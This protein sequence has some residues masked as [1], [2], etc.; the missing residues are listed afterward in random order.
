M[1]L[2][3]LLTLVLVDCS[4]Q[5]TTLSWTNP[6]EFKDYYIGVNKSDVFIIKGK[7]DNL[8]ADNFQYSFLQAESDVAFRTLYRFNSNKVLHS[9]KVG[10]VW[11]TNTRDI[12]PKSVELGDEFEITITVQ[13]YGWSSQ[14]NDDVLKFYSHK[15]DIGTIDFLE[16]GGD[17]ATFYSINQEKIAS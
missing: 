12:F 16:V 4:I 11:L 14:I 17:A 8:Y 1:I 5:F 13:E 10:G 7:F 9:A 3:V 6:V 2:S 15:V